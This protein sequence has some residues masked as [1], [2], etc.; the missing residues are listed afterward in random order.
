M[1]DYRKRVCLHDVHSLGL[2]FLHDFVVR[3]FILFVA[4]IVSI[5]CT[6]FFVLVAVNVTS[7]ARSRTKQYTSRNQYEQID[8][9][10]YMKGIKRHLVSNCRSK[11]KT[12]AR[13]R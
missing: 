4:V 12:Y 8:F 5:L 6:F 2:I 3:H 7:R 11:T 1:S 9:V 10:N 13:A